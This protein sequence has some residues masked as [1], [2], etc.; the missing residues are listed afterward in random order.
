MTYELKFI[1]GFLAY[2]AIG[3][4]LFSIAE[5]LGLVDSTKS[6]PITILAW[7]LI[8]A[9]LII[10]AVVIAFPEWLAKVVMDRIKKRK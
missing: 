4:F 3:I 1:L 5:E 8:L 2:I 7:P 10:G 6:D 9:I